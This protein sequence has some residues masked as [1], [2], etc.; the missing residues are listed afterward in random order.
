[1]NVQMLVVQGKQRGQFL[2]F[3]HGE[4]LFGR[5]PE[6]HVRPNSDWISRQHC[7]V[8]VQS[9]DV[10][11]RD[12]GSTNGTVVNGQRVQGELTLQHGDQIQLG[13]LV[14]EVL[15]QPENQAMESTIPD[16]MQAQAK[17]GVGDTHLLDGQPGLPPGGQ[18]KDPQ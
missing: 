16:S 13:P 7:M 12:L 18:P 11:L 6:C 15:I 1:M 3:P 14:L 10:V 4:F 9:S 17:G 8:R 5:G 2:N